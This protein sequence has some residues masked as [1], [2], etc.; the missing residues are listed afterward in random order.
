MGLDPPM[1]TAVTA[2]KEESKEAATFPTPVRRREVSRTA[3]EGVGWWDTHFVGV[4]E[5]NAGGPP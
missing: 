2:V 5:G 3:S 4:G 1:E